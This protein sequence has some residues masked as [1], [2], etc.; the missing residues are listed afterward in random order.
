LLEITARTEAKAF[1]DNDR[2]RVIGI[3]FYN[4]NVTDNLVKEKLR[5]L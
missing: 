5:A 4:N 3:P 1:V 2:Y